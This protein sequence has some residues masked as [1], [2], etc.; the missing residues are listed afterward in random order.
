MKS[1]VTAT[2]PTRIDLAGGTLDI[3]PLNLM[4]DNPITLNMAIDIKVTARVSPRKDSKIVLVSKDRGRQ[5]EFSSIK[6]IH[7]RHSL[8]LLSRLALHFLK[9]DC[10]V[11]IVTKSDAPAGAGI[12]GS[13]ALNIA[14]CGALSRYSGVRLS[15]EK[16]IDIAKDIEAALLGIPTGLQDYG[17]ALYG[18]VHAFTF[19]PG[20]MERKNIASAGRKLE[21][22]VLLFYSGKER[23]SGINNWEMFKR[24]IDK[25]KA[26]IKNFRKITKCAQRATRALQQGGF[27]L[28]D[29]A[30]ED[31]WK[32]RRALFPAI[33]TYIIDRSIQ[34]GKKAGASAARICGAGGGGC[35]ILLAEPDKHEE[36]TLAV[37]HQGSVRLPYTFSKQGLRVYNK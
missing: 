20:G 1:A 8:G 18:S 19:P 12:A 23:S 35:F 22:R 34:A 16:L 30:V 37:E 5:M 13:S 3:W 28:F 10:G 11:E 26:A 24:V 32:A 2:A 25:E 21:E 9:D 36:V 4:F 7:H 27:K 29:K 17:A 31:E 14:L 33:S 6:T 15:K